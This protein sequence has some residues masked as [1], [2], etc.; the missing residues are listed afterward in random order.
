[1][2][3]PLWLLILGAIIIGSSLDKAEESESRLDE[4]EDKLNE[5]G[6]IDDDFDNEIY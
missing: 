3:I 6:L 5:R 1:M 4:L 2:F